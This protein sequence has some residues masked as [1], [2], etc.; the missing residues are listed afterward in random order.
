[1]H[2]PTTMTWAKLLIHCQMK[3]RYPLVTKWPDVIVVLVLMLQYSLQ[4]IT[5]K[6]NT[7]AA[8]KLP[9]R[10]GYSVVSPNITLRYLL[11]VNPVRNIF[12]FLPF[13]ISTMLVPRK[14]EKRILYYFSLVHCWQF[15]GTFPL[16][17][18]P[19]HR[20]ITSFIFFSPP[21]VSC[22]NCCYTLLGKHKVKHC[23][24]RS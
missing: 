23:F 18:H 8:V 24:S 4:I 13:S 17:C 20:V 10:Y 12:A 3:T 7:S 16:C 5:F 9:L 2:P 15:S 11:Y 1:M 6:T 21:P 14:R 19:M 22:G